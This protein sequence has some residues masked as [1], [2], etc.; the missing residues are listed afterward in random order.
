MNDVGLR[1][2]LDWRNGVRSVKGIVGM[3]IVIAKNGDVG[4]VAERQPDGCQFELFG[5]SQTEICD[6]QKK[7]IIFDRGTD[8]AVAP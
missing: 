5:V 7:R 8:G 1:R 4:V 6:C 2:F 3:D